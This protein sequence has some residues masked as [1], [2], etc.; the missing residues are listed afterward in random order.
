MNPF[1]GFK[2]FGATHVAISK[3][4]SVYLIG[5]M[6]DDWSMNVMGQMVHDETIIHAEPE[7]ENVKDFGR[8]APITDF[9]SEKQSF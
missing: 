5:T 8:I 2:V 9:V 7:I 1:V 4:W 6:N 3:D